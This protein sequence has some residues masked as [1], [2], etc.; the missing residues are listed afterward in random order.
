MPDG[1]ELAPQQR[2]LSELLSRQ[3]AKLGERELIRHASGTR[4]YAGTRD[5]V[6]RLA[7]A[8]RAGGIECGD[9]VAIFASN[10]LELLDTVL[11]TGW[12]GAVAVP[13]NTALRGRQ[14]AHVVAK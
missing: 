12:V 13:I 3:A 4:S 11:A 9:R 5:T 14:L 6:A 7:G 8:L 2:T 10:R 1:L